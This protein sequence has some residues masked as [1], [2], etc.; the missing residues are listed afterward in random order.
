MERVLQ[1]SCRRLEMRLLDSDCNYALMLEV[2]LEI[3]LLCSPLYSAPL[4]PHRA[5]NQFESVNGKVL[6]RHRYGG[7][8][9]KKAQ[10]AK[11]VGPV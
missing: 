11:P 3:M 5:E 1:S 6:Q 2:V 9:S 10:E 8:S 4:D 7:I